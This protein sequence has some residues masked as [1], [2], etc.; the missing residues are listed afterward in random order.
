MCFGPIVFCF[1]IPFLS[2]SRQAVLLGFIALISWPA[3][4]FFHAS[5]VSITKFKAVSFGLSRSISTNF[6]LPISPLMLFS[7]VSTIRCLGADRLELRGGQAPAAWN[8][9][10]LWLC[11]LH[12]F[13]VPAA[14]RR[15]TASSGQSVPVSV[16]VAVVSKDFT[17]FRKLMA[18]LW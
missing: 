4:I 10:M 5:S 8:L 3:Q 7:C 18:L 2:C 15:K 13:R 11:A 1:S 9:D 14:R 17:P 12:L 6:F 16:N